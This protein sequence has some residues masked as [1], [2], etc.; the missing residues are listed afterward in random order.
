M[1]SPAT[2]MPPKED[3]K[4]Q[5]VDL[6]AFPNWFKDNVDE[7]VIE[8]DSGIKM[9]T[10]MGVPKDTEVTFGSDNR[11]H[12]HVKLDGGEKSTVTLFD[13][14]NIGMYQRSIIR[15][16]DRITIV[17]IPENLLTINHFNNAS[18]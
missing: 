10:W 3:F 16:E 9:H 14:T 1:G 15:T 17:Y 2:T 4:Y 8:Y 6:D 5:T 18:E 12:F 11:F 7:S 13:G